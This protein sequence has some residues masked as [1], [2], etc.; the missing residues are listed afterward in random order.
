[1]KIKNFLW[2][3]FLNVVLTKDNMVKRARPG[4]PKCYFCHKDETLQHLFF[5]CTVAKVVWGC[6]GHFLGTDTIPRS[7]WQYF[8][9][10][11]CLLRGRGVGVCVWSFSLD[12]GQFGVRKILCALRRSPS[13]VLKQWCSHLCSLIYAALGGAVQ[14]GDATKHEGWGSWS[15][16]RDCGAVEKNAS[17]FVGWETS[18]YMSV[19]SLKLC[20]W[21]F[22]LDPAPWSGSLKRLGWLVGWTQRNSPGLL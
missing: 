18:S 5:D 12:L 13:T 21:C 20:R 8:I 7:A 22:S 1:M 16:V 9:W 4:N 6:I 11:A 15:D 3:L 19:L 14:A 10:I 17:Q 2:Q